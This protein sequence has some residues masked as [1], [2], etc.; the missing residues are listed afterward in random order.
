MQNDIALPI[1]WVL[2]NGVMTVQINRPQKKNAVTLAMW[3]EL[4]Q[5][6]RSLEDDSNIRAVI[7]T[8]AGDC[9]SAGA[10]ISEFPQV[11]ATP[12]QV[13]NYEE[14]VDGA[15]SAIASLPKPT[16]AAVSGVCFAG[17][18]ALAA[19]AD[20]RVADATAQFSVSAVR[21]GLVYNI[22]KCTRLYQIVGLVP[23]KRIL[24]T[25]Q[26]FSAEEALGLGLVDQIADENALGA[27]HLLAGALIEGAPLA[28][29]GIKSILEALATGTVDA[30][31]PDLESRIGAADASEDHG[32][33]VRAFAEKR[34]PAFRGR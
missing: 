25:G 23:A 31:R 29:Q 4:A 33:A 28:I 6:F 9:F 24:L 32:E 26:R 16:I 30:R 7:L 3:R 15:L 18:V 17:G 11:R 20:F 21:M 19:S 8:G 22:S 13:A 27:A 5:L 1:K 2:N 34:R 10:D 12:E 14:A